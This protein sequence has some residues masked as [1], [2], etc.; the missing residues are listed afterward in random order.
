MSFQKGKEGAGRASG[1]P[2]MADVVDDAVAAHRGLVASR[3]S[4]PGRRP[5][6]LLEDEKPPLRSAEAPGAVASPKIEVRVF[7]VRMQGRC[8][9]SFRSWLL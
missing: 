2:R 1:V 5:V 6:V 8:V 4:S 3:L 7:A 9:Q